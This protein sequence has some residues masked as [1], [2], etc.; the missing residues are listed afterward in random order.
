MKEHLNGVHKNKKDSCDTCG[1][2][3]SSKS[4]LSNHMKDVHT[5]N[6]RI[7]ECHLCELSFKRLRHLKGHLRAFHYLI[8]ESKCSECELEFA[9]KS[10]HSKCT[11]A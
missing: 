9:Q 4:H 10:S 5:A 3:L 8:K 11:H 1:K 7:H 2:E 6:A